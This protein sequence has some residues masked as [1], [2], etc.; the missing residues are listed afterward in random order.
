MFSGFDP[1]IVTLLL[2]GEEFVDEKTGEK[3]QP[4]MEEIVKISL[5]QE[6]LQFIIFLRENPL[7]Q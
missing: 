7:F 3:R 6:V 5:S 1:A 4:T 2:G